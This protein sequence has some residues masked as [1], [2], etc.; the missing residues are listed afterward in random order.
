M[1]HQIYLASNFLELCILN[2]PI[3]VAANQKYGLFQI[4]ECKSESSLSETKKLLERFSCCGGKY[5]FNLNSRPAKG[6]GQN[7]NVTKYDSA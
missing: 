6:L 3:H 2:L 7:G 1:I 5:F 4:K